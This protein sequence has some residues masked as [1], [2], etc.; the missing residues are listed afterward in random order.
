MVPDVGFEPTTL[1]LQRR[2]STTE[3]IRQSILLTPK[4][5]FLHGQRGFA[6]FVSPGIAAALP[7]A[8]S[9]VVSEASVWIVWIENSR[10]GLHTSAVGSALGSF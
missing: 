2:S 1:A 5:A 7:G 8:V 6:F 4:A 9:K 3:L 10:S